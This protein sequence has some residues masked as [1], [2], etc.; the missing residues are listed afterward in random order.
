MGRTERAVCIDLIDEPN[1]AGEP[2]AEGEGEGEGAPAAAAVGSQRRGWRGGG[3]LINGEGMERNGS[4]WVG[5]GEVGGTRTQNSSAVNG[6]GKAEGNG[7][8]SRH[9]RSKFF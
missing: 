4:G 7:R 3:I 5:S 6:A 1:L 8:E 2:R 9:S